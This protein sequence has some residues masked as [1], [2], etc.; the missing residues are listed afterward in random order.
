MLAF[1]ELA[2]NPQTTASCRK[3]ELCLLVYIAVLL[4]FIVGIAVVFAPTAHEAAQLIKDNKDRVNDTIS[5]VL[6]VSE[7]A[8]A[9]LI[10]I[11]SFLE[12]KLVDALCSSS[13]ISSL[14]GSF[15]DPRQ[16]RGVLFELEVVLREAITERSESSQICHERGS[17]CEELN[18]KH[19]QAVK[20]LFLHPEHHGD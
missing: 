17:E 15:C 12:F 5:S 6:R 2:S 9:V 8:E 4:T 14:L 19:Q 11:R 18:R 7:Q 13:I 16:K 3:I 1:D 10:D 20:D